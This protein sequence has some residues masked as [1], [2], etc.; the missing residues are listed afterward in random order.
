MRAF[1]GGRYEVTLHSNWKLL[2][3]CMLS[4]EEDYIKIYEGQS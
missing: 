4:L 3:V 2:E 1:H